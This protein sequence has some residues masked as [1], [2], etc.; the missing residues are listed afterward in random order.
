V[1][2]A[3]CL[4]CDWQGETGGSA[5]PSCGSRL[6]R[7]ATRRARDA[8]EARPL[9][10]GTED[11]PGRPVRPGRRA[12][13]ALTA[14]ITVLAATVAFLWIRSN[15]P[16]AKSSGALSGTILYAEDLGDGTSR[17]WRWDLAADTAEPGPRVDDP[18][19]LVDAR[20]GGEGWIGVTS[21]VSRTELQASVLRSLGPDDHVAPL[22]RGDLIGWGPGGASVVAGD[23]GPVV[24]NCRRHV[25]VTVVWL[26]PIRRDRPFADDVCG[27]L[28]SVGR[29]G[30]V[31]YFTLQRRNDVRIA[32]VSVGLVHLVLR[33][34]A[35]IGASPAGDLV[36]APASALPP[37]SIAPFRA[38]DE[39]DRPPVG[40]FGTALFFRGLDTAPIPFGRGGDRLQIDRIMAW[41]PDGLT[42][43]VDGRLGE[44][45][46]LF[47]IDGGPGGGLRPPRFVGPIDGPTWA[48]Y[49]DD[50]TALV[51]SERGISILSTD[52][53]IPLGLPSGA[54][55]PSGPF[56][57]IP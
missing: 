1:A 24:G 50:E 28:L 29:G 47:E 44:Q 30:V 20:G 53:L 42:A 26:L 56:V 10:P 38:R 12:S 27:D 48:S 35:M 17:L 46:G 51:S 23:R 8:A 22:V 39:R 43:L 21:R 13:F 57:W 32:Y 54:A 31:T 36:V 25:S 45:A 2:D 4:R 16:Q 18:V 40:V 6:Y 3:V 41:T 33:D 49:A 11:D 19:E 7:D 5:C 55:E 15:T 14:A 34:F 9:E 52:G 37:R